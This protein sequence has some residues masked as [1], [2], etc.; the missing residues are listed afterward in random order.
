MSE[1]IFCRTINDENYSFILFPHGLNMSLDI[2]VH[3]SENLV[4]QWYIM[5]PP[6]EN[7][8]GDASEGPGRDLRP[9]TYA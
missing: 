7:T 2:Y 4:E 1:D 9:Y 3:Q 6:T 8:D 5:S